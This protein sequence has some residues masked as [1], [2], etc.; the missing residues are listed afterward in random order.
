MRAIWAR[1]AGLVAVGLL[2]AA[3]GGDSSLRVQIAPPPAESPAISAAASPAASA[4]LAPRASAPAS[5]TAKPAAAPPSAA[6]VAVKPGRPAPASMRIVMPSVGV[7]APIVTL[8][9]D[10][11]G[12]MQVP[13]NGSDVGWYNFSAVPGTPGNAVL[14]GH[15]D[16]A[17]SRTAVFT[18]LKELKQGDSLSMIENGQKT[19]FNVFWSKSWP[20]DTAPL[21]LI[22]GSAPSPTLTL[23]TCSGTFDRASRNYTERLVVRAKLP[24]SI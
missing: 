18:R 1:S 21:A 6:G 23:I 15:V 10:P 9:V 17:I 2:L 5:A 11:D 16:T 8:G 4:P 24:G 19:D 7:D 13:D 22:L 20:D 14:S 3:C 12:R